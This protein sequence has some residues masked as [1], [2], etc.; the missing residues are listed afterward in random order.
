MEASLIFVAGYFIVMA[1]IGFIYSSRQ[2]S[3]AEFIT[4]SKGLGYWIASFSAR[5][6]GESG[7]FF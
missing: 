6:T 4:A 7:C 3:I 1:L 5:A 2:K